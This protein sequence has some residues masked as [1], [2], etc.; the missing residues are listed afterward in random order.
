MSGYVGQQMAQT[1]PMACGLGDLRSEVKSVPELVSVIDVLRSKCA[2]ID[3]LTSSLQAKLSPI[4][5]PENDKNNCGSTSR[6]IMTDVGRA[7]DENNGVLQVSIYRLS[8]ILQ[9]LAV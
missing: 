9:R 5:T 6:P 1:E 8:S 7:I 4:L 3:C 2:E